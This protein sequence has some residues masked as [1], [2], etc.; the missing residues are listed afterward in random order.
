MDYKSIT[1]TVENRSEVGGST[2]QEVKDVEVLVPGR[3]VEFLLAES[4][5]K[6]ITI[7]GVRYVKE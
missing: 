2:E 5:K 4:P 6:V 1:L 3:H 7:N